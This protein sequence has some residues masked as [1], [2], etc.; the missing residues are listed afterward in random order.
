MIGNL[1]QSIDNL[2]LVGIS[3]DARR[4]SGRAAAT[5]RLMVADAAG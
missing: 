4:F 2:E 3:G 5:I 1:L